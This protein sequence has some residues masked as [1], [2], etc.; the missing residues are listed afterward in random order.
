MIIIFILNIIYFYFFVI[1]FKYFFYFIVL[2][3]KFFR[4]IIV[5]VFFFSSLFSIRNNIKILL[6][7]ENISSC[8]SSCNNWFMITSLVLFCYFGSFWFCMKNILIQYKY[9]NNIIIIIFFF[10]F[11]F[12]LFF[13]LLFFVASFFKIL[14]N[15]CLFY[16]DRSFVRY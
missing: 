6:H 11:L 15:I 5:I 16:F 9:D 14:L 3:K 2:N 4:T 12:H 7:N 13:L 8:I 10:V 1:I